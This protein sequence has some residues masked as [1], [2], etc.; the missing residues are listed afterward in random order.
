M[1]FFAFSSFGFS[2][3]SFFVMLGFWKFFNLSTMLPLVFFS[4]SFGFSFSS[5]L[6]SIG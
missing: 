5:F 1:L 4:S 3:S 6:F 2:I